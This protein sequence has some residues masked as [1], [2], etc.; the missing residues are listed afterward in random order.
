MVSVIMEDRLTD[1][2][3]RIRIE[4]RKTLLLLDNVRPHPKDIKL[5]NIHWSLAQG[6]IKLAKIYQK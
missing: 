1:F 2:D 6:V 5:A 4:Y 3:T